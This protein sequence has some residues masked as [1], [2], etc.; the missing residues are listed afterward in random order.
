MPDLPANTTP[1]DFIA[2]SYQ[3]ARGLIV[4]ESHVEQSSKALLIDQMKALKQQGVKT[5][6]MEHLFTDLHQADLDTFQRTGVL[7]PALKDRL[8]TLD[9][10]HMPEYRGPHTYTSVVEVAGKHG[11]RIRA[12]DCVSSYHT[13][14]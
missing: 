14:V 7:P 3:H 12:L 11:L 4:C 13:R 1:A 10:G 5:L 8:W 2:Q 6:Y 9:R